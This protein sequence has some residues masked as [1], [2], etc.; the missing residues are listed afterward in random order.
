MKH[1]TRER[2]VRYRGLTTALAVMVALLS[3]ASPSG[4]TGDASGTTIFG[5]GDFETI[6]SRSHGTVSFGIN[7]IPH[8]ALWNDRLGIEQYYVVVD[9]GFNFRDHDEGV[10][11]H[12][13]KPTFHYQSRLTTMRSEVY[14]TPV[15]EEDLFEAPERVLEYEDLLQQYEPVT[16]GIDEYHLDNLQSQPPALVVKIRNTE[17]GETT[18]HT[19]TF[20]A[21]DR[22]EEIASDADFRF[23]VEQERESLYWEPTHSSADI[24]LPPGEY[25]AEYRLL[26]YEAMPT[27]YGVLELILRSLFNTTTFDYVTVVFDQQKDTFSVSDGETLRLL[28]RDPIE[29]PEIAME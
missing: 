5:A 18:G 27:D 22:G 20:F 9:S 25:E 2:F 24:V 13:Y 15:E 21:T 4:T 14:Y 12:K 1:M 23:L 8:M 26:V 19:F 17:T 28:L 11:S 7:L 10:E 29:G 3:C 6:E 16:E